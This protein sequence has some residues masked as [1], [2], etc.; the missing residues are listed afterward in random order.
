MRA[1]SR[2]SGKTILKI[3]MAVY[4]LAILY[5]MFFGFGRPQAGGALRGYRYSLVPTRIPLW[6]PK[7]LSGIASEQWI[8]S[9]G[10]LLAFVPFG[11][12]AP[13]IFGARYLKFILAFL[14][15]ILSLEILQMATRLGSFDVH[16]IIVNA[17]GAT[18]G[19]F[20]YRIGSRAGTAPK[21][22]MSMA[23]L[24][25]L[26]S[27]LLMAFAEVFNKMVAGRL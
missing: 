8:F 7:R 16:D 25:L 2:A 9:L 17:L 24:I 11:M 21:K 4:A 20:S 26:F 14:L 1:K 13:A 18:I 6:F 23:F 10:N 15:S 3:L 22:T 12:F 19:Y 5:F 27:L